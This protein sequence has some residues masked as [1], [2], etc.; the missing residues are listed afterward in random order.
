M[1]ELQNVHRSVGKTHII[2]GIDLSI[3]SWQAI[4]LVWPNWCGKSSLINCINGFNT[5]TQGSVLFNGVDISTKS[6]EDR[7]NIG[8][9][10]VFQ[11]AGIFKQLTL[12]ENLALAYVQDLSRKQKLLPLH[13]LPREMKEEIFS[14]LQELDLYHKKDEKAGNLSWWQMRLLEI[15]RLYLQ[16]TQLYLLDEPTA[17][18]S[19]KLKD[20]VIELINKIISTNKTVIIVEHDF[21]FLASFVDTFYVMNEGKILL[22]G[23][24]QTIKES[25]AVKELYFGH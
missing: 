12:F 17:W 14:V 13:F 8:I 11:S 24:H 25:T 21:A 19:P 3:Q 1:L 18:V 9:W 16:K 20:K 6:V 23:D 4:W 10:R 7:A 15:G 22:H 5:I 2:N